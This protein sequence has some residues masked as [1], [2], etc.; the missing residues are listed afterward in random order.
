MIRPE[1]HAYST[2]LWE[3]ILKTLRQMLVTN[4]HIDLGLNWSHTKVQENIRNKSL[5]SYL[6]LRGKDSFMVDP[7]PLEEVK[8]YAG[9][10]RTGPPLQARFVL[11]AKSVELGVCPT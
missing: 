5:A 8:L 4:S 10:P 2:F 11:L 6:I 3:P 7:A 1:I 9:V